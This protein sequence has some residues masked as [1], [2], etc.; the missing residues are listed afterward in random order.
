MDST[1]EVKALFANE[2]DSSIYSRFCQFVTQT[3]MDTCFKKGLIIGFSGGSDSVFLTLL[4]LAYRETQNTPF[5]MLAV[6]I[7][8]GIRDDEADRDA[9][10]SELFC[11]RLGV[12]FVLRKIDV[13]SVAKTMKKGLE[14]TAR[15]E[16]YAA[17]DHILSKH[18][19]LSFVVTGHHG[20]DQIETVLFHMVRGSGTR[21]LAGIQPIYCNRLHPLLPFSKDEIV[22][23]CQRHEISFV[24]DSTNESDAYSRNYIRRHMLPA[25][26]A[27]VPN[28]ESAVFRLTQ[29][30][31]SDQDYLDRE[32][33]KV[34][35]SA[36]RIDAE[37]LYALHPA[38]LSRV[39][40][41]MAKSKTSIVPEYEH[42]S[43]IC[44][45]SKAQKP[46]SIT[47]PGNVSFIFDGR[48]AYCQSN[49][50]EL[51]KDF[52]LSLPFD[53]LIDCKEFGFSFLLSYQL[54]AIE[55]AEEANVYKYA[56]KTDLSS[57]ILDN[58]V[59]IRHKRDGDSYYYGGMTHKIKKLLNDKKVPRDIREILPV[60]FDSKGV[61]WVPGFGVRQDK[62]NDQ[63]GP[64]LFFGYENPDFPT[65]A[66]SE[67]HG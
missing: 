67:R 1:S 50:E 44:R 16:R 9:V 17:F 10:F 12:P 21:G 55:K 31:A 15:N 46:F 25:M 42:L 18:R 47:L 48:F 29:N 52:S 59:S 3:G 22:D 49:D 56:T 66:H 38:I 8:H 14:E 30:L 23:F 61:L 5:S 4:L 58:G 6:H 39:V 65:V 54:S 13:P 26:R 11:K 64:Y 19:E 36:M 32:A 53:T 35:S 57:A 20:T 28:P 33:E 34:L 60:L 2:K 40:L 63:S 27:I 41:K 7:H 51:K 24:S 37:T 43:F 62:P 45:S